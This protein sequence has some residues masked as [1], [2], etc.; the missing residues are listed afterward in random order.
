M[1]HLN[2]QLDYKKINPKLKALFN[3]KKYRII[4]ILIIFK[5]KNILQENINFHKIKSD[6]IGST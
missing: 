2:Q 6:K 5:M 1:K 3:W 4:L